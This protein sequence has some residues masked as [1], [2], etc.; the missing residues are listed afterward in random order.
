MSGMSQLIVAPILLPLMTA[1][2]MLLLGEKHRLIKARL[3]LLS[4]FAGLGVA[5]SLLL[6]ALIVA[7]RPPARTS[8]GKGTL[9]P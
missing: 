4:T 3:N 8:S 7:F 6:L 1:A 9:R 5:V 2:V